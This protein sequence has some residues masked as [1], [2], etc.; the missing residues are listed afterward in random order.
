MELGEEEELSLFL[1]VMSH[2]EAIFQQTVVILGLML[3]N[4]KNAAYLM[5]VDF[6]L[7]TSPIKFAVVSTLFILFAICSHC[8]RRNVAAVHDTVSTNYLPRDGSIT[9]SSFILFHLFAHVLLECMWSRWWRV[10]FGHRTTL[11]HLYTVQALQ[12]F[13]CCALGIW[14]RLGIE[15]LATV[16][17]LRWSGMA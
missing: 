8:F 9:S 16:Y 3:N 2:V 12:R 13:N 7:V 5:A 1:L 6:K 11:L 10:S 17:T 4:N 14:H 15:G